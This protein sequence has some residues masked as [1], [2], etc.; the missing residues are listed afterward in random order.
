MCEE[1]QKQYGRGVCTKLEKR[2]KIAAPKTDKIPVVEVPLTLDI[3]EVKCPH[4][5]ESRTVEP[6]ANY[7]VTCESCG[8]KYEI[9]SQI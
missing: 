4:C 3:A 6:D 9:V 7:I 5:G 1:H 8:N 2:V